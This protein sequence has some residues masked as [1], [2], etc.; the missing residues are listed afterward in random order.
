MFFKCMEEFK[1]ITQHLR[2]IEEKS[3][4]NQLQEVEKVELDEIPLTSMDDFI[5]FNAEV[6]SIAGQCNAPFVKSIGGANG[7][8]TIKIAW[9]VSTT[10][11]C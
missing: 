11:D 1:A 3:K 8:D 5:S 10:I 9:S 7:L 4:E 2:V 6:S